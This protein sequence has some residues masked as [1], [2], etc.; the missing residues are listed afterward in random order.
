MRPTTPPGRPQP[1]ISGRVA[2]YHITHVDNLASIATSGQ[3]DCD[4]VCT[5]KQT[6]PVSIAYANLK[7]QRGS[8]VVG[9]AAGGTLTSY[10]PFYFAPRS[11]M[12][13]VIANGYVES[14][15]G[16]QEEV[17]HLVSS[18]EALAVPGKFVITDGHPIAAVSSQ[19]DTL[20]AL[21]SIDWEIM[22]DRYWRDTD[23]DGNRKCRRQAE[24]LVH[25]KA[26]IDAFCL[27]GAMNEATASKAAVALE[28]LSNPPAVTVRTDWYY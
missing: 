20:D 6:G 3:L 22:E 26:P 12:L 28:G 8:K 21:E 16:G 23:E 19:F 1:W 15:S 11:P 2:V 7:E 4:D 5:E 27:C 9:L 10:V 18:V 24:F 25:W 13:Y 14:Y 17:V